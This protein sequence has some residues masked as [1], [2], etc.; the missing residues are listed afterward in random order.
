LYVGLDN[1]LLKASVAGRTTWSTGYGL[2]FDSG[3]VATG[4]APPIPEG[5]PITV[6]YWVEEYGVTKHETTTITGWTYSTQY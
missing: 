3:Y 5:T 4:A 2:G 6:E 1:V